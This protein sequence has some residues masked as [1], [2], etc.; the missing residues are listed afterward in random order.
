MRR[1]LIEFLS[2]ATVFIPV[3][4]AAEEPPTV[5][6]PFASPLSL[7]E[8]LYP[9]V[10]SEAG[11]APDWDHVR[12]HFDPAAVIVLRATREETRL[13]DVD[14]FIGDFV[15]F[16]DRIGPEQGFVERVVSSRVLEYGNVA[17]CSV[18]YEAA[19]EGSE[20]PPQRGLDSWHL[21][22]REGRWWV[23]SVVNEVESVAGPIP[24]SA[25]SP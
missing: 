8:G 20:R 21:M 18:V 14:S 6:E 12:A 17:H 1:N 22:R 9:A 5:A 4:L 23:V 16:Y 25:R 11:G 7:V 24:E 15:A 13:F 2:V 3:L 19:V 10:S